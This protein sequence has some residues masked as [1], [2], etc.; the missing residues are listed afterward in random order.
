MTIFQCYK[1]KYIFRKVKPFGS[2]CK[3][4]GG[5]QLRKGGGAFRSNILGLAFPLRKET[6]AIVFIYYIFNTLVLNVIHH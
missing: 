1:K 4:V 5:F 2:S 6:E 3:K